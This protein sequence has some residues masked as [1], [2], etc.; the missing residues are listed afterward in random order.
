MFTRQEIFKYISTYTKLKKKNG[1]HQTSMNKFLD[2]VI[3]RTT[4]IIIDRRF[5]KH[6]TD[7]VHNIATFD[8][9]VSTKL[10]RNIN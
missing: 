7:S 10:L 4:L 1:R 5:E 3:P 9:S 8:G 2:L 6:K